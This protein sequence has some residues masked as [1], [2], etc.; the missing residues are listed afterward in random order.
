[1]K[2][3]AEE[4]FEEQADLQAFSIAE[5]MNRLDASEYVV[6]KMMAEGTLE[7]V[8]PTEGTIRITARSVRK[9]LYGDKVTGALTSPS[10]EK[11]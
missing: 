6:R 5:V 11:P 2:R 1:M 4:T 10:K 9:F 8:R 7:V 3:I